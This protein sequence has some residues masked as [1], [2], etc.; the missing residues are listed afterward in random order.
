MRYE[1][2]SAI[3]F[4][5]AETYMAS[6]NPTLIADALLRASLSQ[7]DATWV[8]AACLRFLKRPEIEVRWAALTAL[9]HLVR[10]YRRVDVDAI[11]MEVEPLRED[12]DLSGKVD[13]LLDDIEIYMT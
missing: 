8:E 4:S 13:D 3:E 7:I 11:L 6:G 2:P 1:E 5:E 10:R 9:E 12:P